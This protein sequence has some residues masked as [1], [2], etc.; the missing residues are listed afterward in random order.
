MNVFEKSPS[1]WASFAS[2]QRSSRPATQ[3]RPEPAPKK[4]WRLRFKSPVYTANTNPNNG[5][6]DLP[7]PYTATPISPRTTRHQNH[8][9]PD[10]ES[11]YSFLSTFD[12]VFLVDDSSSM[13]G[14]NWKSAANAIA[15]IAPICTSHDPD[16][17]D[18]YFLNQPAASNAH[19][20]I[21]TPSQV[22]E[23]FTRV[24]PRGVT[25]VG[26]RLNDILKPYMA[27]VER[28][29]AAQARNGGSDIDDRFYVRPVNIIV[30]T[31]GVFTD[32][33]ESVIMGVARKLDL[34]DAIAWQVGIQFFQVGDDEIIS[35]TAAVE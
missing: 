31:D 2:H 7:P 29:Q 34:I 28:M 33:A 12:T 18:I 1:M 14:Q 20:N 3:S 32:D 35:G 4:S 17:I 16:G 5:T 23:I 21:T 9:Q 15:A 22:H 30:I 26:K 8:N 25:P 24:T 13:K 11:P 6:I 10:Q 27:R 19:Y